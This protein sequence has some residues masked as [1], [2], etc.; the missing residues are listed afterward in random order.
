MR[1]YVIIT[2]SGSDLSDAKA[3]ELGVIVLPLTALDANGAAIPMPIDYTEFYNMLRNK[4]LCTTSAVSPAAFEDAFRAQAA[5]GLDILYLGFSSGLS[6]TY[7]AGE[8]AAQTVREEF[9]DCRI[10]T[11]D[12][13]CASLGEGL[14]VYLAVQRKRAGASLEE[15]RDF[16]LD[17]RLHLCHNFTVDDLM[18][19]HRGGRVRRSTAVLGSVLM[20]KP[21]MHVDNEGHLVKIGT[22]RGRKK[23]IDALLLN[24]AERAYD[25]TEQ[26]VF[27]SHGD[28]EADAQA[29]AERLRSE[30]GVKEVFID[31]VGAVIG[32]H[33]GPG[34][35]AFFF[36]GKER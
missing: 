34:T 22:A 19:L 17:T 9:P 15:V 36:L 8:T 13:L 29:L 25:L 28:C 33:S 4:G 1:D 30:Y 3:A 2:D 6:S 23:A 7:Q 18:F 10:E 24:M 16:A 20:I 35:L 12:T 27:I 21:V 11:V 26:T 31:Y 14:L 32:A 5:A